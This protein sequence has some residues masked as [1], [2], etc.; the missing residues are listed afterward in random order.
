M[1]AS[2]VLIA[3]CASIAAR[4][5]PVTLALYVCLGS[6]L[7]QAETPP[8]ASSGTRKRYASF[9]PAG[10]ESARARAARHASSAARPRKT[11][12]R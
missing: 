10:G 11:K 9:H 5:S 6:D 2:G 3:Q 4:L 1:I 8:S 7:L 12:R